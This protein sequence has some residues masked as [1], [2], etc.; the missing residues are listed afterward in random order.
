MM[1]WVRG[2]SVLNR[3][4]NTSRGGNIVPIFDVKCES[5]LYSNDVYTAQL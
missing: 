4:K 2:Q 5:Q 3:G 1:T